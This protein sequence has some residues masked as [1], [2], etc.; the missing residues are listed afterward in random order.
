MY[1]NN[2]GKELTGDFAFC[3][4]CSAP[5]GAAPVQYAPQ[6]NIPQP[7]KKKK[8]LFIL[9]PILVIVALV[10]VLAI[11]LS[12]K[13]VPIVKEGYLEDYSD[14]I[15]VGDAFEGFFANGVW[16]EFKTEKDDIIV[17]FNGECEYGDD[18]VDVCIQFE[19]DE[20]EETFEVV[21]IERDDELLSRRE[22]VYLLETV[23]EKTDAND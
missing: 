17:E 19:V 14:E 21:C 8:L 23:Y 13:Y 20:D 11:V 2:C 10:A 18:M 6:A 5:T 7:K 4:F 1:C 3:P 12:D 16:T 22:R 15:T 9:I